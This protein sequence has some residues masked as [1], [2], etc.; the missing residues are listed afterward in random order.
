M[1]DNGSLCTILTY[2]QLLMQV[3]AL[4]S[5][6]ASLQHTLSF[7]TERDVTSLTN[8]I[9]KL[10]QSLISEREMNLIL[11]QELEDLQRYNKGAIK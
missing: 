10:E 1:L 6:V 4:K 3:G 8:R 7:Y 5:L 11:G 2:E 9:D